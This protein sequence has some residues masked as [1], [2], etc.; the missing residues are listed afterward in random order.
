VPASMLAAMRSLVRLAAAAAAIAVVGFLVARS[1]G[2]GPSTGGSSALSQ[3]ATAAAFRAS[4]PAGW[5]LTF[6]TAPRQ[7]PLTGAL[8]LKPGS[9]ATAGLL[10]GVAP[11]SDPSL[12]GEPIAAGHT[13]QIV[14]I[15]G[16]GF[17]RYLGLAAPGGGTA[18]LYALPTT[19]GT[20]AALCSAPTSD[21]PFRATCE[22]VL[23]TLRPTRGK[24]VPP[25]LDVRYAL[26]LN[27][28]IARLNAARRADGPGLTASGAAVRSRAALAL[29]AAHAQAASAV[30]GL[31]PSGAE[32]AN[33]ALAAALRATATAYGRLAQAAKTDDAAAYARAQAAIKEA[34]T[35]LTR[36]FARLSALGYKVS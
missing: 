13:P 29:S 20:I 26:A 18:W 25:S 9:P 19:A 3:R 5:K 36:A 4:Y 12:G 11:A 8:D 27:A 14:T 21:A 1:G 22:R 30:A 6:A 23:A 32:A 10:I 2:S 16:R 33:T 24:A 35:S 28:A 34:G 31:S 7:L 15:G 17:Y